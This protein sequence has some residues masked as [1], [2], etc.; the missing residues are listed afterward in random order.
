[1][2]SQTMSRPT[3][4]GFPSSDPHVFKA[5][6]TSFRI[7]LTGPHPLPQPPLEPGDP[8]GPPGAAL[9]ALGQPRGGEIQ[10]P[11]ARGRATTT[12]EAGGATARRPAAPS[13]QLSPVGAAAA[14]AGGDGGRAKAGDT[15]QGQ[16]QGPGQVSNKPFTCCLR[17]YGVKVRERD[18]RRAN[19]GPFAPGAEAVAEEGQPG[20]GAGRRWQRVFGLFGTRIVS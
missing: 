1:M 15:E 4:V 19:A 9:Q 11:P 20:P 13:A 5:S 2:H 16:R 7:A 12:T 14:A 10:G 6:P 3:H 8:V 17:Q 18:P